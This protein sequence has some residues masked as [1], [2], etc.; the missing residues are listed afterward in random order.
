MLYIGLFLFL[1][2]VG[3]VLYWYFSPNTTNSEVNLTNNS[4]SLRDVVSEMDNT[5]ETRLIKSIQ[6][7]IEKGTI[8][9]D[10]A[11]AKLIQFIL[12]FGRTNSKRILD[13]LD[14]IAPNNIKPEL[15]NLNNHANFNDN[16]PLIQF[17]RENK[18]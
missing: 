1:F 4:G 12:F 16:S 8:T 6:E 5:E 14:T 7:E 3:L 11:V 18:D 15:K 2:I 9:K 13:Y 10:Q 17:I